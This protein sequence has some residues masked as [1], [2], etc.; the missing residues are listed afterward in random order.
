MDIS[1]VVDLIRLVKSLI[2]DESETIDDELAIAAVILYSLCCEG[3]DDPH[4]LLET[5]FLNI[6]E[7]MDDMGLEINY[8]SVH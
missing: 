6:E 1:R 8:E 4:K 7:I 2:A 3:A 5:V